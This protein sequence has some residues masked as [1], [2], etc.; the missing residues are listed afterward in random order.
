MIAII[1]IVFF[2]TQVDGFRQIFRVD[3]SSDALSVKGRTSSRSIRMSK[4]V[5]ILGMGCFWAPQKLFDGKEGVLDTKVGF[6]GGSNESPS[7]SSVCAGDGHIEAV[8]VEFDNSLIS[9]DDILDEFYKQ[10]KQTLMGQKGQYQSAIFTTNEEQMAKALNRG[11]N[12]GLTVIQENQPFY[13]AESYHQQY[14]TKQLPRIAWLFTGFIIDVI[15]NLPRD[16][17]KIGA[18]MTGC[19]IVLFLYE[20]FLQPAISGRLEKI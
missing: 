18:F 6:T 5:A 7:Y 1:V 8:R 14:E 20:R 12:D 2:F 13:V 11:D 17:Y 3:V 10:D 9:Y 15:P 19:Y 16:V 4:E